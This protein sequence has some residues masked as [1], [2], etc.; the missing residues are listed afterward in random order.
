LPHSKGYFKKGGFLRKTLFII[1]LWFSGIAAGMQFAKFSAAIG[2]IQIDVGIS[3]VYSGW[4]LSSLG[5]ISIIFGVTS[6]V[7]VS[8]F[9]PVKMV[10]RFCGGLPQLHFY[11]P[12]F[13]NL[14]L[15]WPCGYWKV[16]HSSF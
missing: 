13:H 3:P 4:L 10:M 7:I 11:K 15:C 8:R 6:G 16:F 9:S 2:L 14:A 12:Y 1:F 5:I